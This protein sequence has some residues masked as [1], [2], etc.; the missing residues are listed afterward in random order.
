M[1]A[2]TERNKA[3]KLLLAKKFDKQAIS[4]TGGKGTAYGWCSIEIKTTDPC[5][6]RQHVNPCSYYCK[7]GYCKGNNKPIRGGWGNSV[8]QLLD[9]EITDTAKEAI[10]GVEFDTFCADDGYNTE[11]DRCTV[12]VKFI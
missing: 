10:K 7:E 12:R 4:V 8:R 3:V 5:P 2:A 11:R 1:G 9:K 6:F